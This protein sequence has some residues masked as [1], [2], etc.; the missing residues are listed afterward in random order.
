MES[1]TQGSRPRPRTQKY[2]RPSPRTA[3]PGTDHLEAKNRNTRSQELRTQVQV[4]FFKKKGLKKLFWGEKG[5]KQLFSGDLKLKKAIF[6]RKVSGV[7]QKNKFHRFKKYCCLQAE[8]KTIFEDLRLR[9]QGLASETK[10]KDFKICPRGQG[11][12]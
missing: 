2:P 7:F 12:P 11:C 6:F 9:C 3:F 1:K 4:F 8:G 10:A 5:L